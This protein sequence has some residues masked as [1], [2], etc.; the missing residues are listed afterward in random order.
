MNT[1]TIP[2]NLEK[3]IKS[4]SEITG[5]SREELFTNAVLY[6]FETMKRKIDLRKELDA[7][8]SISDL[9]LLKFEK[10]L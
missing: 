10:N 6:Y 7:W 5:L 4:A 1:V 8:E 2:K 9:D 3:K